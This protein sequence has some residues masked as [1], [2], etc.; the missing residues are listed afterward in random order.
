LSRQSLQEAS[1]ALD[2]KL[3]IGSEHDLSVDVQVA[4]VCL[5]LPPATIETILMMQEQ[6]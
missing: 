2:I 5:V 3:T 1:T 6:L 4:T